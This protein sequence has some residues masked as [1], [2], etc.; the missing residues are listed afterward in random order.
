MSQY[1]HNPLTV[2]L[3][4]QKG[5][6]LMLKRPKP[7]ALSAE[8]M[9]N[10]IE[11]SRSQTS[12]NKIPKSYD[13]DFPAFDIPV[14]K[15]ILVYVPNFV[16]NLPDGSSVL[17]SDR[18]CYHDIRD[19]RT[20]GRVR[21]SR[22]VVAPELG[23]DGSCPFCDAENEVLQLFFK[24]RADI[25]KQKGI[26]LNDSSSKEALKADTE[27]LGKEKAVGTKIPRITFPIVVIDCEEGKNGDN[28][29]IRLD[30]NGGL[31][32]KVVW[33]SVTEKSY[34][35]QWLKSLDSLGD[36]EGNAPTHPAGQW[37][38]LNYH[39]TDDEA[40]ANARDAARSLKVVYRNM[41]E[42]YVPWAQHFDEMAKEWTPFKAIE[43]LVDNQVRDMEEMTSACEE[44]MRKTRDLLSIYELNESGV[45]APALATASQADSTLANFGAVPSQPAPAALPTANGDVG[46]GVAGGAPAVPIGGAPAT[47]VGAPAVPNAAPAAPIGGGQ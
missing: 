32:G 5:G 27:K 10:I 13:P 2:V 21:C 22:D 6:F 33:Y 40:K 41:G 37:A 9:Q 47:P 34:E 11:A 12:D 38:I 28:S 39:Y 31:N 23:L 45:G 29:K 1:E 15:K 18:A 36:A 4:A 17:Q 19:G 46:V 26:D 43:T 35:E 42:N 7:K 20:F 3:V 44:V 25:A 8:S 24:K 30:A 14:N 16:A